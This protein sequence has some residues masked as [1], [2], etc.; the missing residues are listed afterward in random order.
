MQGGGMA[1]DGDLARALA[2]QHA[3]QDASATRTRRFRWGVA[4]LHEAL[5][6][7]QAHNFLRVEPH[8]GGAAGPTAAGLALEADR[9]LGA[10]GLG[11]R[12]VQVDDERLGASLAP[13]FRALDWDC[14]PL[15]LM[16]WR[17]PPDR[18]AQPGVAQEVDW[19]TLRPAVE[20]MLRRAPFGRDQETVRQ[21]VDRKQVTAA[22]TCL[23][24]F[25]ARVGGQIASFCELYSDGVTAQIED[26]NTFEEHRGRGLARAVVL[27]AAAAARRAGNRLVFL[28]AEDDDWPKR[29]YRRLGF[30]PLGRTWTFTRVG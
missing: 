20:A 21:L 15:L 12:R 27:H 28:V 4:L 6:Y 24:L 7:S 1:P 9:L 3:I 22:V 30:D 19:P 29:L 26:V 5:P 25:A 10:A 2:F 23:R 8:A 18:P 13:G 14:S 17:R 16:A 11:H